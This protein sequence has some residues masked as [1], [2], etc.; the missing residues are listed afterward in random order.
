MLCTVILLY[1]IYRDSMFCSALLYYSM[2]SY[3]LH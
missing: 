3:A 1:V 2:L